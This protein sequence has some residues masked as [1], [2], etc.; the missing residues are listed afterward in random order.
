MREGWPR[1]NCL[2]ISAVYSAVVEADAETSPL[3]GDGWWWPTMDR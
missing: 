2:S 3:C 1:V